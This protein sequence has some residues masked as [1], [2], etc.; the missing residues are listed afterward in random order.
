[1][2]GGEWRVK[3]EASDGGEVREGNEGRRYLRRKNMKMRE[4]RCKG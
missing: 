2:S 3:E 4:R 1:M